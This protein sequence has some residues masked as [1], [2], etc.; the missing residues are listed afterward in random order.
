VNSVF[1]TGIPASGK[2][3]IAKKIS[4]KTGVIHVKADSFRRKMRKDPKLKKWVNFYWKLDEKKYG[5]KTF[6]SAIDAEKELVKM[7]YA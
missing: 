3:F 2:S 4:K 5:Y 1:I 7:I 6:K